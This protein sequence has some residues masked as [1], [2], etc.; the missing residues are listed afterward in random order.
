MSRE[1]DERVVEMRFDNRQF[2]KNA[3]TSIDTIG[4]LSGSIEGLNKSA[5][6]FSEVDKAAKRVDF[7]VLSNGAEAVRAKFSALEVMGVTAL[8][9]IT[10]S[11]VNAG[12][13]VAAAFTIEPMKTGFQEYETQINAVQTIMANTQHEGTTLKQVN[14][15]LDELNH[16]ADKTIYNFTEMTR[17][18]GTFTAAGVKLDTS[19]QSIKGIA[20]LAAV[21]G[22]TSTQASTAMYQLSQALAA[23]K[24]T[25]MDWNSV[26]NAG[27]GGKVFQD[28]LTRTSELLGTGAKAA[29]DTYG[30]FRESLSRGEWL[31]TEV[32]TETLKQFAGAYSEAELIEQG[33][34]KE[35]AAEI[36][37][38]AATAE[39][40]ATKVKTF[41]QLID[42][43]KEAA[44]S[45][46]T[47]SWETIT[48]D[49]EEAKALWTEVS[50]TL[51]AI[52]GESADARNSILKGWKTFG[53]RAMLIEALRNAFNGLL[54]VIK[55]IKE[56]FHEIFPPI[57]VKNLMDI[58]LGLKELSK[59]LIL[60]E[61]S[62][63]KVRSVFK[64]LFAAFDIALSVVK[65]LISGLVK[66]AK[67]FPGLPG[68]I[69]NAAEAVGK[70]VSGIRDMIK[71]TDIF[72]R[73][74][75]AIVDAVKK[76]AGAVGRLISSAKAKFDA[77]GFTTFL[78]ILKGVYGF[79]VKVGKIITTVGAGIGKALLSAFQNGGVRGVIDVLNGGLFTAILVNVKKFTDGFAGA[80]GGIADILDGVSGILDGVKGS[81]E[82]WQKSINAGIL[83]KIAKAIAILAVSL[84]L[85]ASINDERLT[86]ALVGIKGMFT[87]LM[88]SLSRFNKMSYNATGTVK[89]VHTMIGISTAVLILAGALKALAALNW[90]Q[91]SVG[92]AGIAGLTAII[93]ASALLMSKTGGRAMKGAA[94]IVIFSSAIK[95]LASVCADMA[96][97]SWEELAKGLA[98]VGV[99]IAGVDIFLNT[100]KFGKRAFS[101]AL[102]TI[103][104]AGA[105]KILAS[106]AEDFAKMSWTEIGKGLA[107]IGGL[108]TE[109]T[110]F[111]RLTGDAKRVFSTG[112]ALIAMGAAMKIF[113]S[114]TQE[115]SALSWEEL[116]R[117][118]SGMAGALAAV[119]ISVKLM[120]KNAVKTGAG[121][122]VIG[123]AL[124]IIAEAFGKM[125]G[126][127][128]GGTA[129]G[130]TALGGSLIV[131]AAGLRLM[132]GTVSSAGA[133]TVAAVALSLLVPELKLLGGMSMGQI[134]T[135]LA[136]LAGAFTV[137][138]AAAR[139]LKPV[140]GT[141]IRVAG[142][143]A[144]FG[145]GCA[146]AGAGI[147]AASVALTSFSASLVIAAASIGD[148][149]T[150]L[151]DSV[152]N[153][154][155]A[156][157]G[158]FTAL[159]S[160]FAGTAKE[161]VPLVADVLM[162]VLTESLMSLDKYLP[163]I[164]DL[165][166]DILVKLF[167]MLSVRVPEIAE[168]AVNMLGELMNSLDKA[169][170][171]GGWEKLLLSLTSISF[172]F[173]ALS[174][175]A[176]LISSIP[177]GGALKG[178][179]AFSAVALGLAGLLMILGGLA[180]IQGVDALISDGTRIFAGLGLAIGA[181]VGS[182]VTGLIENM[183]GD[184]AKV[185][186]AVASI[187]TIAAAISPLAEFIGEIDL[188]GAAK[189]IAGVA[190]I[191]L[192]IAAI[193]AALGG[194]AQIPGFAELVG[195]GS[196]M[197]S[198]I[199]TAIGAFVGSLVE[200]LATAVNSSIDQVVSALLSVG[201]AISMIAVV[202]KIVGK[203][204]MNP[205]AVAE[206]FLGVATAIGCIELILVAL[207]ALAQ[208]PGF[209]WIVGEGGRVLCQL[210][211]IIG[212]FVGSIV[213]GMGVG[214]TSGLPQMGANL[215]AFAESVEPFIAVVSKI[216]QRL[217]DGITSLAGAI[218]MLTGAELLN[219][220][221]SFLTGGSSLADFG[222]EIAAFG[223]QLQAFSD[224]TAK[225]NNERVIAA[226]MATKA[227]VSVANDVP[228]E[229]GVASWFAGENNIGKFG[230]YLAEF[231]EGLNEF[232]KNIGDV[233]PDKVVAAA[234]A[235]KTLI[236]AADKVPNE[237]GMVSWFTGD[238]SFGKFGGQMAA[239]GKGL[240]DFSRAIPDVDPKTVTAAAEASMS[241]IS[242]ADKVPNDGGMASWFAGD[243]PLG[244]FGGH[245]A[246]FGKGLKEFSDNTKDI[247]QAR[248]TG[249]ANAAAALIGAAEKVP[250]HGGVAQWFTGEK[251]VG[252]FGGELAEFGKGLT[253]FSKNVEGFDKDAAV[254]AMEAAKVLVQVANDAPNTDGFMG[255]F[256][257]EVPISEFGGELAEF[258]KGMKGF[259]DNVK[260][261]EPDRVLAATEA[262]GNIIAMANTVPAGYDMATFNDALSYLG[263]SIVSYANKVEWVDP[264]MLNGQ[265]DGVL[266]NLGKIQ[267]A[268]TSKLNG[269][270]DA[271]KNAAEN[272]ID[273]FLGAFGTDRQTLK[274]AVDKFIS[275]VT[276]AFGS[277]KREYEDS[278]EN[279]AK[280]FAK[281]LEDGAPYAAD[282]ARAMAKAALDAAKSELDI[283]SPSRELYKVGEYAGEG[284]V[285][286]L[287]AFKT[288]SFNAGA[289]MGGSA[290]EG[291]T[292]SVSGIADILG[293]DIDFQPRIRPVLDLSDVRAKSGTLNSL[294]SRNKAISV[295]AGLSERQSG[296]G[297]AAQ[298][299]ISY[300]YNQ[301]ITSPKA[302]DAATIYRQSNNLVARM[303]ARG[304]LG[305]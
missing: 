92:L 156:I 159:V 194:L 238:N 256:N 233:D 89:A 171:E 263:D 84:V 216:D 283:H 252:A 286:A 80:F 291:L 49:F 234:E 278:G 163:K 131:L 281:G 24:V 179:V 245:I 143:V 82:A 269:F 103:A 134:F 266:E 298:G 56:A 288:R 212:E 34:T 106:A 200:G 279:A 195:G 178:I 112:T 237:G 4:K 16:Y 223:P 61:E 95:L 104:V 282:A 173:L 27:M 275:K 236:S 152:S 25:L 36:S 280:G 153:S 240:N 118:L 302:L 32:L 43:L 139:L 135:G 75:S 108:L 99:L 86:S 142:A 190:I 59:R 77:V 158:A 119:V 10:N 160:S 126:M 102:G 292:R 93:L 69:L 111:T 124:N 253:Q 113:A 250:N 294:I 301:Y 14:S 140:A 63:E 222:K 129:K 94:G 165:L 193:L 145:V 162:T 299:D 268:D 149:I 220:L 117:G 98:G 37:R 247:D 224:S 96:K 246:E 183:P 270:A 91:L 254:P 161:L 65:A 273:A 205:A 147:L 144:L 186:T 251:N 214:L 289:A 285:N 57:T 185:V 177:I 33:F 259:S 133:L 180:R 210:G 55:P 191:I 244:G 66:I 141:M 192:G 239:F 284:F 199:G 295:S 293:G 260:G 23:G 154:A 21:S 164:V 110:L 198:L 265:I 130:L 271:L 64:G 196:D 38:M 297:T 184:L 101:A 28:A 42:T 85:M 45:G 9:N 225:V 248:V 167:D 116:A 243:N 242:A 48:G 305:R 105:I 137:L 197:L 211:S 202:A 170:G 74:V 227:L 226:A 296:G 52:I 174:A 7:S 272:G 1:I 155:E 76:A 235:S 31:T 151:C 88:S 71:E 50:D 219:G 203:F 3:K 97:M 122:V 175:A 18:I 123:A 132:K 188:K 120:P 40:A 125:G 100:A 44:Q 264:D 22:S 73:S 68:H 90:D 12:K 5:R 204:K 181:F 127:S 213:S 189:G 166:A 115:L 261:L 221:A 79:A 267:N 8:A 150:A 70:F 54:S 26:V 232:S 182:L 257:G 168:S 78:D 107:G 83:L 287:T 228:N 121:L 58:S 176:K 229:G 241:L 277:H 208:I 39:N 258:G 172:I 230:G 207:G 81:L 231:G 157:A 15:A 217:M 209:E 41:T 128:W 35:Q 17:N 274:G 303:R 187:E 262:A 53:G 290:A 201:T 109:I 2:E 47:E 67:L 136:A 218:L 87:V 138:G 148:V 6:G 30:S 114:A 206:G 249:A 276:Y 29:I 169:L 46:W 300:T 72:G 51:G 304:V 215:S 62:A 146:L 13:R 19:V 60:S 11:A 255:W 20:N